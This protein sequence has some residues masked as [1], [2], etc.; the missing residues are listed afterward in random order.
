MYFRIQ[1]I[2][3]AGNV[4]HTDVQR[5]NPGFSLS[6]ELSQPIVRYTPEGTH[7]IV[8]YMVDFKEA[9]EKRENGNPSLLRLHT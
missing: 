8:G 3:D 7:R 4:I 2:D 9:V 5:M 6:V 1:L